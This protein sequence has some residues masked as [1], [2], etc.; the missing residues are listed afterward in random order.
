MGFVLKTGLCVIALIFAYSAVIPNTST[1]ATVEVGDSG[2]ASM[3]GVDQGLNDY[4]SGSVT[5]GDTATTEGEALSAT[6]FSQSDLD[7]IEKGRED[8]EFQAEVS[9]LMDIIINSLYQ[10]KRNFL[11]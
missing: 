8:F 2:D 9:R 10:K 6:G 4:R 5:D 7:M 1:Y 3:A 11:T